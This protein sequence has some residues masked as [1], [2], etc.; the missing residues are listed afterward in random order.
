MDCNMDCFDLKYEPVKKCTAIWTKCFENMDK[1]K[2]WTGLNIGL[3]Y[4]QT[5]SKVW[6]SE[7][8][9]R[10]KLLAGIWTDSI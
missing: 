9:D 6:T 2:I 1:Q 5:L 8:M 3:E 10:I 4:G 7:N